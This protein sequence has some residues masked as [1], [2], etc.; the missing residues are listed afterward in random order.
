M[1][2][3]PLFTIIGE[4]LELSRFRSSGF[5]K[6]SLFY[7]GILFY[8][9][10]LAAYP[11]EQSGGKEIPFFL[12]RGAGVALLLFGLWFG[13][14]DAGIRHAR[15]E[16]LTGFS[17][18]AIASGYFW[19]FVAG[20]L[21]TYGGVRGVGSLHD[22]FAYSL[23]LGFLFPMIFAHAPIIFPALLQWK[24]PHSP[25]FYIHLL[26]LHL[27]LLLRVGTDLMGDMELRQWGLLLNA[28]AILLFLLVTADS[29]LRGVIQ[30]RRA[31]Q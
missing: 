26:L 28:R 18:R 1:D 8:L 10:S 24:I 9:V 27:D 14:A 17:S 12:Q 2:R 3:F 29:I 6:E 23:F 19:L 25:L 21:V 30:E 5:W 15:E 22:A 11:L 31:T 13:K 20:A 16:G 7:G 4:R